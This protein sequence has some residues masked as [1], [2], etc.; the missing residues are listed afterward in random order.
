MTKSA[1]LLTFYIEKGAYTVAEA[2]MVSTILPEHILFI[3]D[4]QPLLKLLNCIIPIES[5]QLLP[6]EFI[7]L[8]CRHKFS[9]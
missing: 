3:Y 1:T 6:Y 4:F 7:I 2:S 8:S 5:L 9:S